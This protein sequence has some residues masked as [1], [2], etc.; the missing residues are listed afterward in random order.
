MIGRRLQ[1]LTLHSATRFLFTDVLL[2]ILNGSW[3]SKSGKNLLFWD[4]FR[5]H[6]HS[7]SKIRCTL[8]WHQPLHCKWSLM[9]STGSKFIRSNAEMPHNLADE[10]LL[11]ATTTRLCCRRGCIGQ[12]HI[13]ARQPQWNTAAF[14]LWRSQTC[15]LKCCL[16]W[17]KFV[18]MSWIKRVVSILW[19]KCVASSWLNNVLWF[20]CCV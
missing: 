11:F 9:F 17:L 7:S 1:Q 5:K 16:L 8:S 14:E 10:H 2:S 20:F 19:F 6:Y 18:A 3:M 4:V 12:F 13:V 15:L